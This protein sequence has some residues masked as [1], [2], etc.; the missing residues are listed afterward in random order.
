MTPKQKRLKASL[1]KALHISKRYQEYYKENRDAYKELLSEYFGVE[2]SLEL[3]IE[4]LIGLVDWMNFKRDVLPMRKEP[5]CTKA[6]LVMMQGLWREVARNTSEEAL[7]AF[8]QR[9]IHKR[10]L[11]LHML[12]KTEA[13]KVIPVLKKMQNS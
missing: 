7:L 3:G 9:I 5:N 6:Q 12:S 4:E 8:V 1:I 11:H 13:Q 2:S 10:Y